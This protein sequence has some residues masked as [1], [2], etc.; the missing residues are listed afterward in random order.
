MKDL[1]AIERGKK[2]KVDPSLTRGKPFNCFRYRKTIRG[3]KEPS[4]RFKE[5]SL[6]KY[7]SLF[8]SHLNDPVPAV[9]ALLQEKLLKGAI[10]MKKKF[11]V[12]QEQT[13]CSGATGR[14]YGAQHQLPYHTKEKYAQRVAICNLSNLELIIWRVHLPYYSYDTAFSQTGLF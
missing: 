5:P 4:R 6:F 13:L 11:L 3:F 10:S 14:C 7:W 9:K 12:D 1:K 8:K 2:L